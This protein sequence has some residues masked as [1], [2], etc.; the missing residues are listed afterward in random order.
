T[1]GAG[2]LDW[3]KGASQRKFSGTLPARSSLLV[4]TSNLSAH[5]RTSK[6]A[7]KNLARDH[8][9]PTHQAGRSFPSPRQRRILL[10]R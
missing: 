5:P 6:L 4:N 1:V 9:C 7:R 8:G 10:L 2:W 3:W